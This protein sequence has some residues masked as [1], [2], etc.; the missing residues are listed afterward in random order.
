MQNV[1]NE[2]MIDFYEA[3]LFMYREKNFGFCG[4]DM[5]TWSDDEAQN[6]KSAFRFI[7][8]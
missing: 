5:S 6:V 4:D 3:I 1:V 2:V 8:F 7:H